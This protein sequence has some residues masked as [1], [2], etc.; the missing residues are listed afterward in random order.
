MNLNKTAMMK[1]VL[2]GLLLSTLMVFAA[3]DGKTSNKDNKE[4]KDNK[5]NENQ[6]TE[7]KP[8]TTEAN[9]T[10]DIQSIPISDK[11][12]GKF[13]YLN[14]P[15]KYKYG[16]FGIKPSDISD[17]DKEYFAVNG[18]LIP[19]EG[20]SCKV[21]IETTDR[22]NVR[23]NS[24]IVEKSYEKAILALGGV[25]VN[26]VPVPISEIKRVGD[27]ELIAKH[28]GYSISYN[29]LDDIKTFVIHRKDKE[30]WIQF[31]LL[32]NESGS[33]TI[34]ETGS[35]ETENVSKI[36]ADALKKDI[37]TNGKAVLHI[38][39]DTNKSTL[40][41]DGQEVVNEISALL[42]GNPTLKLSIEGH[43]DDVGNAEANRKLSIER[44]QTVVNYLVAIGIPKANL[45]A[46]G[47]G[48]SKPMV[49]NT[50]EENRAKNRRVELVKF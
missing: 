34:L 2:S 11:D 42:K 30:V 22:E 17:F 18:K 9:P 50:S 8:T 7:T 33:I 28:Y 16:S 44:A 26:N 47:F 10:F 12:L 43:T 41:P 4:S 31:S 48:A 27:A 49:P 29:L 39:F 15:D 37:E 36:T 45:K 20:K 14:A 5:Q 32:N 40:K 24:L 21:N 25:Q 19:K 23:F 6:A 13:P 38:N 1:N 46:N 3:C 35:L